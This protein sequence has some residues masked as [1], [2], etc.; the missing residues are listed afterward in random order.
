M[1]RIRHKHEIIDL[2]RHQA[3]HNP[4]FA[5]YLSAIQVDY[6]A[7]S[8]I[9]DIPFLPIE[10]FKNREIKTGNFDHECVFESSGTT[11]SIRSRNFIRSI[12]DYH[13][14]TQKI[15]E[16]QYGALTGYNIL[17]LLPGYASTSSLVSMITYFF[18]VSKS[19]HCQFFAGRSDFDRLRIEIEKLENGNR[20]TLLFGVTHG[21]IE[22]A[23]YY[24]RPIKNVIVMETG[25]MKGR[26]EELTRHE[27][28]EV[29]MQAW[30]VHQVHSEYGMTELLSQAYAA[31]NGLFNMH[32]GFI[33][34]PGDIYDPLEKGNYGKVA[35]LNVIDMA[36]QDTCAFIATSDVGRVFD[37]GTFEVL[38]R[39]D[40]AD[41][42]GCNLMYMPR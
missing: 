20:R 30:M 3:V 40:H 14:N 9:L 15:F 8:N 4:D 16:K 37:N 32:D 6:R 25:G 18:K 42:R 21:L 10:F 24:D 5:E 11:Q 7:I 2:F 31:A 27:L 29:L 41:I 13:R 39:L 19:E 34:I 23:Q 1:D 38:G 17:A 36:N 26:R 12:D 35:R 33:V 28:H 22:F